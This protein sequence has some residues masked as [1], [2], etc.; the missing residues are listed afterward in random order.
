MASILLQQ[1]TT[2]QIQAPNDQLHLMPFTI[3]YEGAA[4]VSKYFI[5]RSLPT[6][7]LDDTVL[8]EQAREFLESSF[9]G[10]YLHGTRIQIPD[11]YLGIVYSSASDQSSSSK[12][13]NQQLSMATFSG[14]NNDNIH[15]ASSLHP[16]ST[17]RGR[18]RARGRKLTQAVGTRIQ[19]K[20]KYQEP[21]GFLSDQDDNDDNNE[22]ENKNTRENET[23][24]NNQ[25]AKELKVDHR[26]DS[27]EANES[28]DVNQQEIQPIVDVPVGPVT[29]LPTATLSNNPSHSDTPKMIKPIG[30]FNQL[31]IWN[32]DGPVDL[33]SDI[34]ARSISDWVGLAQLLHSIPPSM[35]VIQN[36]N[37][38]K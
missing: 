3:N 31:T 22:N 32:P 20:R 1:V 25:G 14:P 5:T 26:Q 15:Q 27:T 13:L 9:R 23:T 19:S 33:P 37:Q 4:E 24:I 12:Q 2:D 34:Y 28:L 8:K 18:R 29:N 17:T 38:N 30:S 16:R 11:G 21:D 36:E 6:P 7:T 10:R 35:Q